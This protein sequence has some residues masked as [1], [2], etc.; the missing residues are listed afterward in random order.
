MPEKTV[1][2]TKRVTVALS[3]EEVAKALRAAA[4]DPDSAVIVFHITYVGNA[5][6]TWTETEQKP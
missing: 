2:I 3:E 6:V 1:E 4:G 5:T